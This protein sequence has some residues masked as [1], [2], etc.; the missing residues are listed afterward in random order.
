[1]KT[2]KNGIV[3]LNLLLFLGFINWSIA[4]KEQTLADGKLVLLRLAPVD[5]RSLIQGDY[6]RLRYAI[7]DD[8]NADSIS[9]VGFVILEL[10]DKKVGSRI[11]LQPEL[12]PI[13][14]NQV[15]VK[16]FAPDDWA[17]RIG[18]ESFFFQEG[19]AN[20]YE[21][22]VFGGLRVDDAGNSLLVGL[23]D[24]TYVKL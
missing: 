23:Y 4:H 2:I 18:A 1:M 20:K 5:P 17:F 11:S 3:I 21:K 24:S 10:D 15:A 22:A 13:K 19:Q 16:Y 14:P 8:I 6:M 12:N 9:K 7:S